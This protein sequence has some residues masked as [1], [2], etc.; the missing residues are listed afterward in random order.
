M[1]ELPIT[2]NDFNRSA[3]VVSFI[4]EVKGIAEINKNISDFLFTPII[5]GYEIKYCNK[6]I[7]EKLSVNSKSRFFK[8]LIIKKYADGKLKG[9]FR[10]TE[11]E[12]NTENIKKIFE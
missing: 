3:R 6:G 11:Q 5:K 1:S 2:K 4:R 7:S 10:L 12:I 9:I 8:G